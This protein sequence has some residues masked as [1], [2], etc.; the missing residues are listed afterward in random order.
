MTRTH[1]SWRL[2]AALALLGVAAMVGPAFG[3]PKTH[4]VSRGN[5]LWSIARRYG[6]SVAAIR[7]ANGLE[8]DDSIRPGQT[9]VIPE[10]GAR[11]RKGSDRGPEP[12]ASSAPRKEGAVAK[13]APSTQV[14]KSAK[15]RGVNPCNTPDPGF[16]IYDRWDRS[17]SMG[18]MI[19]PHRG[20]VAKNGAFDVMIHFH[21]HE[22]VRKE[23]VQVMHGAVLV[24]IDLGIGSG[25]YSAAFAGP[26]SFEKL[27]ASVE[28]T[29]AKRSGNARAHVRH[30]GL[31][32]WSA[33]YGAVIEIL[34]QDYAKKTVDTVV[35]LDGLH[36]GYTGSTLNALQIQ[37]VIDFAKLAA[38]GKKTMF[39]SHSSIIPPGYASTTETAEFLV[40]EVGGRTRKVRPRS[41]DPMGLDLIDRFDK[42]GFH[43]RGYSGNDK[44][45]HCA[46]IGL[47]RDVLK[48][49][50][51]GRW[52][53]P[54]GFGPK[55]G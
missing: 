53:S 48:V 43:E 30:V 32:A 27:V 36:C 35:L 9:L 42:A 33:G 54:R 45:D 41:G 22:A 13:P 28:A 51:R 25:P 17:V 26:G 12:A 16:G 55:K 29:M 39:V 5:S 34:K 47:F 11:R 3:A 2:R 18:Q 50:V 24:G 1:S 21:G 52:N 10:P 46:H 49:H 8:Q 14:Q 44:M 15:E 40:Q 37:P 31:S 38:R 19:A 23:W 6:V 7:Q 20:G 4:E